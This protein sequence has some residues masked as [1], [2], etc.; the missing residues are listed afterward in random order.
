MA[1]TELETHGEA[2]VRWSTHS[3]RYVA[4]RGLRLEALVQQE[5]GKAHA[6]TSVPGQ[7]HRPPTC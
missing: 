4:A 6:G 5:A 7:E 3:R 2:D 1:F